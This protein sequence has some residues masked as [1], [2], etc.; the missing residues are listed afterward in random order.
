MQVTPISVRTNYPMRRTLRAQTQPQVTFGQGSSRKKTTG[1]AILA[2]GLVVASV[3]AK[4]YLN[5]LEIS[6]LFAPNKKDFREVPKSLQGVMTQVSSK[7]ADGLDLQ[8]YYIPAQEGKKTVIFCH[9]RKHNATTFFDV[10]HF[11]HKNGY[12]VLLLEYRG[13]GHNPGTP[14]EKGFR[15]DFES[16]VQFLNKKKKV[17]DKDIVLWGFSMGGGVAID[18]ATTNRF[19]GLIP[20][21]TFTDI[22]Q[23]TQNNVQD[24][25]NR[26]VRFLLKKIPARTIPIKSKFDNAS[27]IR[28][29][30]IPTLILHAKDDPAVPFEMAEKLA[31]NNPNARLHI[32][33]KGGHTHFR[34][35]AKEITAFLEH[36]K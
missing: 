7:T 6:T 10:P 25:G 1:V 3:L 14:S 11:L 33:E 4:K 30:T 31:K 29:I 15:Q 17:K 22:K 24:I 35:T 23:A 5:N 18:A 9:G 32:A 12:G 36:L 13:F 28:G 34:W 2:G 21:S 26:F 27:K 8:H 20:N 16:V 19:A